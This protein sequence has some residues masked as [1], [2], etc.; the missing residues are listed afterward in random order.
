MQEMQQHNSLFESSDSDC[1][2]HALSETNKAI[3]NQFIQNLKNIFSKLL[4]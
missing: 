4:N 3:E 1:D 2:E